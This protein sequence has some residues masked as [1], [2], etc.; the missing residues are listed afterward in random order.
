MV[1]PILMDYQTLKWGQY[2][3]LKRTRPRLQLGT[4]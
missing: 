3:P 2:S 4:L 1:K